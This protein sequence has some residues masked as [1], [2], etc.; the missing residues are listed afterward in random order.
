MT[1]P[2]LAISIGLAVMLL[3]ASAALTVGYLTSPQS[4]RVPSSGVPAGSVAQVLSSPASMQAAAQTPVG[5]APDVTPGV[6]YTATFKD[7]T[8]RPQSLGQWQNKL[9]VINF[10]ATWCAPCK[11]EMPIFVKLHQKLATQGVQIVGIA[12]DTSLNV[13]KFAKVTSINYPLLSDEAG[14]IEFSKRLGNRFG[15]LP[16]TV[17]VAPGGEVIYTKLGLISEADFESI[18][19][20][21]LLKVAKS[22]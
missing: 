4:R 22:L 11:E 9:L 17:V 2:K 1:R 8:G 12:A 13:A 10:W 6:I 21:N 5:G 16:H 19:R 18:L 20:Q 3:L 15:L 14:A 7:M